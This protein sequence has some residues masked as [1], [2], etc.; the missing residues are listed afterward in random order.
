MHMVPNSF[1]LKHNVLKDVSCIIYSYYEEYIHSTYY[2]TYRDDIYIVYCDM[3]NGP[4]AI[5]LIY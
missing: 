4:N 5:A 2:N 1:G 3:A